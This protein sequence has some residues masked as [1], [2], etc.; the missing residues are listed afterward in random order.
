MKYCVQGATRAGHDESDA[1]AYFALAPYAVRVPW[2]VQEVPPH[3]AVH[4]LLSVK[5]PAIFDEPEGTISK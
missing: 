1:G 3:S 2:G 4:V 5:D